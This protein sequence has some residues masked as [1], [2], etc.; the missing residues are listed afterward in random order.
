METTLA[1]LRKRRTIWPPFRVAAAVIVLPL[2]STLSVGR[3]GVRSWPERSHLL[4]AWWAGLAGAAIVFSGT[5]AQHVSPSCQT[6][7]RKEIGVAA[8]RRNLC[9][10]PSVRVS[11]GGR[12]GASDHEGLR[13]SDR[14]SNLLP[15]DDVPR[16]HGPSPMAHDTLGEVRRRTTACS[17]RASRARLVLPVGQIRR[18]TEFNATAQ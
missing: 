6:G 17:R 15:P 18:P 4:G 16:W 10:I 1:R 13:P 11:L 12:C 7:S 14:G 9:C 5:P 2:D 3:Y 8:L